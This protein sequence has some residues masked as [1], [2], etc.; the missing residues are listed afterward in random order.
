MKQSLYKKIGIVALALAMAIAGTGCGGV[1][2][3]QT[4]EE[5]D[6]TIK[7]EDYIETKQEDIIMT[8]DIL[9]VGDNLIHSGIYKSG[10]SDTAEWNYDHLYQ[11][12]KSDIEAADLA[13]INQETIYVESHD[14]ISS[15]PCFGSPTEIGDAVAKAGFDVVLQASNHTLDKGTDA[16]QQT[17]NFWHTKHP[18]ITVL[19]I[20]ASPEDR[21]QVP[22]V[23]VNGIKLAMLNYTYGLNGIEIPAGSE[24][25]INMLDKERVKTMVEKAKQVS[26]LVVFF[27]HVGEEYIYE[28][29]EYS[30]EWVDY[31]LELG[32]DL[33][34]DCHPHV[35]EPYKMLTRADG[36]KMLV[37][38][39]LGNFISTQDAVPRLLGGMAKIKLEKHITADGTYTE[40]ADYS[41]T[42]L[43]THWNHNTMVYATYK[44]SDYTDALAAEHGIL[45]VS[46]EPFSVQALKDLFDQIINTEVTP[47]AGELTDEAIHQFY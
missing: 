39:S 29:S 24:Y 1:K 5:N 46:S 37:F 4:V 18:E 45:G 41:L 38:Y 6:L 20:N 10:M 43:V 11:Y 17:I 34:I 28:P 25:M 8:A 2:F 23:E 9:A 21:D 35:V 31:L 22:V 33:A 15:Y 42:P 19:G 14:N 26:D 3:S 36:H 40:V 47:A 32:V 7:V 16:I 30:K 12:V 27:A 13:I 44:L